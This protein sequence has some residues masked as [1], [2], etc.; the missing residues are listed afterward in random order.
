[1]PHNNPMAMSTIPEILILTRP[2]AIV[3][4]GDPDDAELGA[5]LVAADDPGRV[6]AA[7]R[8]PAAGFDADA[9]FR[10]LD[11]VR[12]KAETLRRWVEESLAGERAPARK[13]A[14]LDPTTVGCVALASIPLLAL[15]AIFVP[16]A[17]LAPGFKAVFYLYLVCAPFT[18]IRNDYRQRWVVAA[19][20]ASVAIGAGLQLVVP[21]LAA[22][23]L[24]DTP[25][26]AR[27]MFFL[28]GI[29]CVIA[30]LQ[31]LGA[32][33]GVAEPAVPV[34]YVLRD[35]EAERYEAELCL[36]DSVLSVTLLCLAA[37]GRLLRYVV[38]P[39]EGSTRGA[40]DALADMAHAADLEL[41]RIRKEEEEREEA[42]A[43]AL[44]RIDE[45]ERGLR[46]L[47]G[48]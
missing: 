7:V 31:W 26:L 34:E 17:V 14:R 36:V 2:L 20:V 41:A 46:Q 11:D 10:S 38:L 3:P 32:K 18:L 29:G 44:R 37:D 19:A 33:P 30:V 12:T 35:G 42:A 47:P 43:A 27:L 48:E 15:A 24:A 6:A 39:V 16:A 28:F 8:A 1:M 40:A 5:R 25:W 21:D 45:L 13:R 4:V 9:A 22:D 23:F